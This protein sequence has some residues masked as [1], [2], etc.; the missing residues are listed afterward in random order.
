MW[1][2]AHIKM[3][4]IDALFNILTIYYIKNR[5]IGAESEVSNLII[6]MCYTD[7]LYCVSDNIDNF[8]EEMLIESTTIPGYEF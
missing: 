7:N 5:I 8:I 1:L 2:V 6:E 4:N 3:M